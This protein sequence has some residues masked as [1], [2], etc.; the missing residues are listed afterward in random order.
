MFISYKILQ[1]GVVF[2]VPVWNFKIYG[3]K[4]SPPSFESGDFVNCYQM[5]FLRFAV[6]AN[7]ATCIIPAFQKIAICLLLNPRLCRF[8]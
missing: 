1:P 6:A 3:H 5:S 7:P 2:E 4:K 8:T